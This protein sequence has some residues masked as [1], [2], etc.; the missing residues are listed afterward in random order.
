[1][2]VKMLYSTENN[3]SKLHLFTNIVILIHKY[4]NPIPQ[5]HPIILHNKL[6]Q[7]N[8]R[9]G[10]LIFIHKIQNEIK[11]TFKFLLNIS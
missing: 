5:L 8:K 11:T 7:K 10:K 9:K 6:L 3:F 2:L 1:M 4:N